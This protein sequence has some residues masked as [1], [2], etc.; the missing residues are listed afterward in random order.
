MKRLSIVLVMVLF[1]CFLGLDVFAAG[2]EFSADTITKSNAPGMGEMSG[3]MYFGKDKMRM[4]TAESVMITRMDKKVAYTLMPS[5]KMYMEMPFGQATQNM[6]LDKT[7]G[8]VERTPMGKELVNGRMTDKY[9][10]TVMAADQKT[11][12][13]SWMD[14]ELGIPIKSS[15]VDGSWSYEYKNVKV[16]PQADSLFEIPAGYTKFNFQAPSQADIEK[17]KK[18]YGG[19][20]E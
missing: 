1:V 10:I 3:K 7:P 14:K 8:E 15:A 19:E 4:E 11:E 12:M 18:M 5:Q 6:P 13:Y 20:E 17:L 2:K 9:K 16:G